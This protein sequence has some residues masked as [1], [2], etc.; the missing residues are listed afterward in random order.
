MGCAGGRE[1]AILTH[2]HFCPALYKP[3]CAR[4]CGRAFE[5][6][7]KSLTRDARTWEL[8]YQTVGWRLAVGSWHTQCL[9]GACAMFL[10]HAQCTCAAF[11]LRVFAVHTQC[12]FRIRNLF[13]RVFNVA[14]VVYDTRVCNV[15]SLRAHSPRMA[16]SNTD[17]DAATPARFLLSLRPVFPRRLAVSVDATFFELK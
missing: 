15:P 17:R 10:V 11:I 3:P 12:I 13:A 6:C 7:Y 5:T 9:C 1:N 2:D 14:Y 4:V 8:V 16:L